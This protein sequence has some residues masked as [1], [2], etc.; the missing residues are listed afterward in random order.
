MRSGVGGGQLPAD[1]Q[2]RTAGVQPSLPH[3]L[4]FRYPGAHVHLRVKGQEQDPR[5]FQSLCLS[6]GVVGSP[7]GPSLSRA[8]QMGQSRLSWAGT[9]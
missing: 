8:P 5:G 4:P 7:A 3:A 6:Q 1:Q 9:V 2:S